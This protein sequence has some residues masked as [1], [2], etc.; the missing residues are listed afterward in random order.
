MSEAAKKVKE[1]AD[2][3]VLNKLNIQVA[4]I[5][6]IGDG[7][8]M[9]HKFSDKS[10]TEIAETQA[11]KNTKQRKKR[12]PE[13]EY[14]DATHFFPDGPTECGFPTAGFKACGCRGAKNI[15][16]LDMTVARTSFHMNGELVP[17]YGK[18]EMDDRIV[19]IGGK[20][21]GTP[22][23]RYRPIFKEWATIFN[24]RFNA[25]TISYAQ[26]VN[27]FEVGGFGCGV[28]ELRPEKSP[29]GSMGMF[30]VGT[31]EEFAYY[32]DKY[33]KK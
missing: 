16:G 32:A 24:V 5:I 9:M 13:Q 15:V 22:T 27:S 19:R 3:I 4:P 26:L 10:G 12:D 1:T 20:G 11:G 8:L 33:G 30:H 31:E 25:D 21:T 28:G 6:L 18:R 17:I 14:N 23:P 2:V 7:P 29:V